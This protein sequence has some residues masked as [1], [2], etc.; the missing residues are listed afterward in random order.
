MAI[1]DIKDVNTWED[2]E[3]Y[4]RNTDP[5]IWKIH[6]R[7]HKFAEAVSFIMET[8]KEWG[9]TVELKELNPL[10]HFRNILDLAKISSITQ[11]QNHEKCAVLQ[12]F[13]VYKN[14]CILYNLLCWL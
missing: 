14:F 9:E 10:A 13:S 1:T 4:I 5:E 12:D 8:A 2:Y 11:Q 6:E 7:A 3:E